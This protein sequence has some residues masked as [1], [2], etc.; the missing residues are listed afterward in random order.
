MY[1]TFLFLI[2]IL[3]LFQ[4]AYLQEV[5][6][7]T[8][9]TQPTP[10]GVDPQTGRVVDK[11]FLREKLPIKVIRI[12][13]APSEEGQRMLL[14]GT[15]AIT[16]VF[17]RA[18]IALGSDFGAYNATTTK[19]LMELDKRNPNLKMPIV[20]EGLPEEGIPVRFRWVTTSICRV[21][22]I[23]DWPTDLDFTVA[24]K[25]DLTAFDGAPL[26]GNYS[27]RYYT[28]SLSMN[29]YEV[30]S[31]TAENLTNKTW[32]SQ[33]HTDGEL[34]YECPPDAIIRLG[35]N[36]KI[37][38]DSVMKALKIVPERMW[39]RVNSRTE[40]LYFN[41]SECK[42]VTFDCVELRLEN[43]SNLNIDE[44]YRIILPN[45]TIYYKHSGPLKTA[46]TVKITGLQSFKFTL[47]S[48]VIP[49]FKHYRLWLRHGLADDVRTEQFLE[50]MRISP[51]VNLTL[52]RIEKAVLQLEGNFQPSTRYSLHFISTNNIRDGFQ[53]PLRE[54]TLN[55]STAPYPTMMKIPEHPTSTV[56]TYPELTDWKMLL[57]GRSDWNDSDIYCYK[58]LFAN[59]NSSNFIQAL[60]NRNID[61]LNHRLVEVKNDSRLEVSQL[62]VNELFG[63]SGLFLVEQHCKPQYGEIFKVYKFYNRANYAVSLVASSGRKMHFW[64]TRFSNNENIASA[65][66]TLYSVTHTFREGK[67]LV[68]IA[69]NLTGSDGIAQ[70]ELSQDS[71]Y[72]LIAMVKVDEELVYMDRVPSVYSSSKVLLQVKMFTDRGIYDPGEI[73]HLKG[74]I[75]DYDESNHKFIIPYGNFTLRISWKRADIPEIV[76]NITL[77][78][79]GSFD[80]NVSI[81]GDAEYGVKYFHIYKDHVPLTSHEITIADPRIPTSVLEVTPIQSFCELDIPCNFKIHTKTYVGTAIG[82]STVKIRWTVTNGC[83]DVDQ[84][85]PFP[86][87]CE[88]AHGEDQVV[89][90]KNGIAIW[91]FR[92]R[93]NLTEGTLDVYFEFFG[94]T[95]ERLEKHLSSPLVFSEMKIS[96]SPTIHNP[97][98]GYTFGIHVKLQSVN[99]TILVGKQIQVEMY[100]WPAGVNVTREL[101]DGQLK[102]LEKLQRIFDT[103]I[104]STNESTPQVRITIPEAKRYLIVATTQDD[105]GRLVSKLFP[106]GKTPEE[107][108]K[109][110]LKELS[111][112]HLIPEKSKYKIGDMVKFRFT[113]PFHDAK[114]LI[115][116]GNGLQEVRKMQKL[117]RAGE[118]EIAVEIGNECFKGCTIQ[119]TIHA[120]KQ[121]QSLILPVQVPISALFDP[122]LPVQISSTHRINIV[123]EDEELDVLVRPQNSIISPGSTARVRIEVKDKAGK[124]VEAQ[125]ALFVVDKAIL[126]LKPPPTP[127][128]PMFDI[129]FRESFATHSTHSQLSSEKIFNKTFEILHR[130]VQHDGWLGFLQFLATNPFPRYPTWIPPPGSEYDLSD[131]EFYDRHVTQLTPFPSHVEP[132]PI[133]K[134]NGAI[135]VRP[136]TG[137][138]HR[139]RRPGLISSDNSFAPGAE[140]DM[141]S[142]PASP[143]ATPLVAEH[144]M[145]E[146]FETTPVF[147]P[148]LMVNGTREIE[149]KMPDN[150]GTFVIKAISVSTNHQFGYNESELIVRKELSLHASLPRIV[151]IGDEFLAGCTVTMADKLFSGNVIVAARI[152]EHSDALHIIGPNITQIHVTGE[153]PVEVRF[154]FNATRFATPKLLFTAG[155]EHGEHVDAFRTNLPILGKQEPVFIATS[156]DLD[157]NQTREEGLQLPEAVLGYGSLNITA[158][159][160]KLPFILSGAEQI[161]KLSEESK[162]H[163]AYESLALWIPHAAIQPYGS[164]ISKNISESTEK[165]FL[166]GTKKLLTLTH[167]NYGLQYI[168]ETYPPQYFIELNAYGLYL[169][170]RLEQREIIVEPVLKDYW[171]KGLVNGIYEALGRPDKGVSIDTIAFAR[172]VMGTE[173]QPTQFADE[174][175]IER[176]VRERQNLSI[177]A[178]AQ[179]ALTFLNEGVRPDDPTV[180]SILDEFEN[181]IRVQGRTAYI[182]YPDS[183]TRVD[184]ITESFV[185]SALIKA[186]RWENP[187]IAKVANGIPLESSLWGFSPLNTGFKMLVLSEYDQVKQSATPDLHL[188]V[189]SDGRMLMNET[190]DRTTLSRPPVTFSWKWY[191]DV[192]QIQTLNFSVQGRGQVSVALGFDF[193][194]KILFTDPVYRGIYVQKAIRKVDFV[195]REAIGASINSASPG[196]LVMVEIQ[197]SSP[198]DLNNVKIIDP[199]PGMMFQLLMMFQ[200]D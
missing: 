146:K 72:N 83:G 200:V 121:N 135:E 150:I 84:P 21:D 122:T 105:K 194:P 19:E 14:R 195:K 119:V 87:G 166:D 86:Q 190:F 80:A 51:Q 172:L 132:Y 101:P 94:P 136:S 178:K 193:I 148:S 107:W 134:V 54:S 95:R 33:V 126:D 78:T 25:E 7:L 118:E 4:N 9:S 71:P 49:R 168:S 89:T 143:P 41:A 137:I 199:L 177:R 155:T 8:L 16:I 31:K 174:L 22:P 110:P 141:P 28:E 156:F 123:E 3:V 27:V 1:K 120:P 96:L 58:A 63:R 154:R 171:K 173:W 124:P 163:S 111:G 197:I 191:Q 55:F 181:L 184:S 29:V 2:I 106:V 79:F 88:P 45:G 52:R 164:A 67:K 32:M 115:M 13:P 91:S 147:M 93:E 43:R 50:Y 151:R 182:S 138:W 6:N 24:V 36:G 144:L 158:G 113:N 11:N 108:G 188:R 187:L 17:N 167:P 90:D 129:T 145:R 57:R 77:D 20:F 162:R 59:I 114:A 180:D 37:D 69:S 131:A 66:V 170:Q 198:D 196:S 152:E 68:Y 98:P 38:K 104:R 103:T 153:K 161:R 185:L 97:L 92:P 102:G 34:L 23:G 189:T 82:N 109:D 130:R 56:V 48:N 125:I 62:D 140:A 74:Y 53:L 133:V 44:K 117:L 139:A 159:V 81:P 26:L 99:G 46:T 47:A 100:E 157:S 176:L 192:H 39:E 10:E 12:L 183:Q 30:I 128:T 61:S 186:E 160:G 42:N 85:V 60:E 18:V 165:M 112:V 175:S 35:F 116:W 149:F 169:A 5:M 179:L 65:N 40:S 70:I 76:S 142:S 15:T 127:T 75:R 64:V 73:I